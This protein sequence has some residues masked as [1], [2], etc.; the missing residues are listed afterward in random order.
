MNVYDE[1][2]I[3][4]GYWFIAPYADLFDRA[5][6]RLF[7]P[8]QVGPHIYDGSGVSFQRQFMF[9][10]RF[11]RL[12]YPC[13]K[14]LV[15]SGA[16]LFGDRTTFDFKTARCDDA[17]C[18]TFILK[19]DLRRHKLHG[20]AGI[21]M[22]TSYTVQGIIE[23]TAGNEMMNMHEFTT[24]E[25]G[26][27]LMVTFRS[28]FHKVIETMEQSEHDQ[29]RISGWVGNNGFREVDLATGDIIF[30]WWAL[31]HVDPYDSLVS[32]EHMPGAEHS[33]WDF[34]HLNSIDK[35]N[36]GD[37]LISSRYLNSIFKISGSDGLYPLATRWY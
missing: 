21:L 8:G 2:S 18:M 31:N 9:D 10:S 4:P 34:F 26:T 14:N 16:H 28:A 11:C 24:T 12:T 22:D 19:K 17:P 20:G 15:W 23:E 1:S 29:D 30:E 27:A 32:H 3:S 25:Q 6:S 35:N 36:D 5:P 7:Q 33:P 37:Y 13:I